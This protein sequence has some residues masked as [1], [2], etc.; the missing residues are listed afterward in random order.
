MHHRSGKLLFIDLETTGPDPA[1]D[2]ITEIGIV[3]VGASGVE[4][5]SSLVNPGVPIPPFIQELTGIDDAMVAGAPAFDEV[6]AELRQRIEGGLFIAHNARFDYGFLRQAY[7][8]LGMT[9]RVDVLCTVKLSRKLFPSE[10]R[11]GLD[12]LVERHGLLVE[13]RHRALADADLLW[14]FWRKLED[15]VAPE[16]LDAAIARQLERRGLETALDPDVIEDLPDRPGIYLFRDQQGAPLYVGRAS[17]LRA[18]V[19]AHFHGDKFT[20]RDMQLARQAHRL[21]WCETAGDIGARLLEARLL[22]RLRPVHNAAPPNRRVAYA[23]RIDGADARGRPELAL[24]S[25]REVD[26]SAAQGPL[27]GPFNTVGKAEMAMASLRNQSRAAMESLRIQAWPHDGPVGMVETGA[28]GTREDVLV[29]DRWRYLGALG[30]ASEWQELLGDAED[31]IVFD[32]DAYKLITGALA[33]GK[34]RVVPLPAPAR[35]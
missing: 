20:Q 23:W 30:Q 24:V 18:R 27:Y 4:R 11:H 16:A 28:Q 34:L 33:A 31:D 1:I 7:K 32:S 22:R 12:A 15:A 10:I 2:L 13:A 14:Q 25:S 8:R 21:D 17:Q 35:A 19:F 9:L 29:I 26:F 5:W 6:A 3:E